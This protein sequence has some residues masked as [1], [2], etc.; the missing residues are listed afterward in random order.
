VSNL[1]LYTVAVLIWGS[2]F[3]AIEF[4]LGVVEPEVSIFYR[5]VM[6]AVLLF[7]WSRIRGLSL[8][9]SLREHGWFVLLGLF[10]FCLNYIL[11]YRAQIHITSALNAIAFSMIVWMNIINARL[12]FGVRAG[13]RVMI[14]SVLGI[15]GMIILFAPQ[16][17]EI[18]FSDTVFYGSLLA[19]SGAI[20]ASFGNM[21]SQGAQKRKL[22]VIQSNA[23]G[24][25]YGAIATGVFA[26]I[27]GMPFNFDWSFGY[28]SSLLY[29]A[30]FGSVV[31]F[32]AYLTLL[33]RIGAHKAGYAMVMFPVVALILS[34][35]FEGL[36]IDASVIAGTVLVLAGNM[37][38]LRSPGPKREASPVDT[39][40]EPA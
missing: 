10:L 20:V 11:A 14:G 27:E 18:S 19:I 6:A 25:F 16:V 30:V 26:L 13:R 36:A 1:I 34:A 24:M 21:V 31:A 12:F 3:F 37:F 38:V 2:T 39:V 7:A 33:G 32:G 9:F 22:P 5:Y 23:W 28:V 4:Q 29:L 40:Q 8:K 15:A 17:G 35:L